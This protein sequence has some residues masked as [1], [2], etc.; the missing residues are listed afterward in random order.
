MNFRIRYKLD[1]KMGT[2]N[3]DSRIE[4]RGF[5]VYRIGTNQPFEVIGKYVIE[6]ENRKGNDCCLIMV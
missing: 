6:S 1:Q 5:D 3:P 2:K 4:K